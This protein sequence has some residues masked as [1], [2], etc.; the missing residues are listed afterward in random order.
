MDE[1]S[2]AIEGGNRGRGSRRS[3]QD[4]LTG[5]GRIIVGV[6]AGPA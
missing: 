1:V 2:G 3:L 5:R 6:S 4:R